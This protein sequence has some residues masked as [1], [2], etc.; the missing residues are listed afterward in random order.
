MASTNPPNLKVISLAFLGSTFLYIVI[1]FVLA[2][3][4]G[5]AWTWALN[6]PTLLLVLAG[7]ALFLSAA[8]F[9]LGQLPLIPRLA[10]AEA[11]GILGLVAAFLAQ[12]PLWVLPFAVVSILLQLILSPLFTS[13][14]TSEPHIR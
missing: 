8:T 4:N 7:L 13:P 5:W 12:S 11:V 2:S 10:M 1:A 9:L 14:E 3:S 6:N